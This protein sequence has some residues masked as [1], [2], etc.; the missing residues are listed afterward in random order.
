MCN[1]HKRTQVSLRVGVHLCVCACRVLRLATGV[2]LD[3]SGSLFFEA[4]FLS[5]T[6]SSKIWLVSLAGSPRP[7]F[8]AGVTGGHHTSSVF[9]R[10]LELQTL[11]LLL[12][13]QALTTE[14][15]PTPPCPTLMMPLSTLI[16]PTVSF[17]RNSE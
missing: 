1:V 10:V 7:P 9:A 14:P 8:K 13:H 11:V 12:L 5:Q 6:Q 16:W 17:S 4:G 2:F 15:A 3:G